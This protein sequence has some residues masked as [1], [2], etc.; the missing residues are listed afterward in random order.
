MGDEEK[1]ILDLLE[2]EITGKTQAKEEAVEELEETSS[3][4]EAPPK[5]ERAEVPSTAV[6][7]STPTAPPLVEPTPTP[8]TQPELAE[9]PKVISFEG[10]E[11]SLEEAELTEKVVIVIAG[12]KGHGKT[13][14][15]FSMPGTISC[16][17]YDRKAVPVKHYFY[18]G[19]SRIRVFDMLRY[20]HP[21]SKDEVLEHAVKSLKYARALLD[22]LQEEGKTDWIVI[23]NFDVLVRLSE[24]TARYYNHLQPFGGTG[25]IGYKLFDERNFYIQTIFHKAFEAARKGVIYTL[26]LTT[27]E[28]VKGGQVVERTRVPKWVDAVLYETDV[29]LVVTKVPEERKFLCHV[30]TSKN[31]EQFPT[32]ATFD[33]TDVGF[34]AF[35][36]KNRLTESGVESAVARVL[37]RSEMVSR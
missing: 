20:Y 18:K 9:K 17:A 32:G 12:E 23:D 13:T 7:A 34:K 4:V 19:D 1:D 33:V 22:Y 2:E 5:E 21:T 29:A 10:E 31:E 15:A 30:L 35:S 11:F 28:I 8:V 36:D 24:M 14:L 16:L 27:Q 3:K 6:T 37:G 25:E 26:Y